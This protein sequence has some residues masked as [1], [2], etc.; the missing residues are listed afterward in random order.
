MRNPP[1]TSDRHGLTP[2]MALPPGEQVQIDTTRQ[3]VLA[4]FDDG[5][6]GRPELTIAVDVATSAILAAVLR[7]SSTQAID[8]APLLA[9]IAVPHP[10]RP[11]WPDTPRFAHSSLL[12]HQRLLT[13][14][15]R[16]QGAAARPAAVPETIVTDR[17]SVFTAAYETLGISVQASPPYTPTTKGIEKQAFDAINSLFCQ[18][19]PGYTGPD[20]TQRGPTPTLRPA[21][22]S[23]SSKTSSGEWLVHYR[24][25]PPRRPAPP[26]P[27][28]GRTHAEPD[29]DGPL[30]IGSYRRCAGQP[31]PNA[32]SACTTAPTTT[33][34]S[35]PT[36]AS[37][38]PSPH[39]AVSGRSTTTP[40]TPARSGYA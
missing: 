1:I 37:P 9:E 23:P 18:H 12:P 17:G 25:P 15:G 4:V 29:V 28:Q 20:T 34:S 40:T 36:T 11:T 8:A 31:S 32:A 3:D 35:P 21:T 22:P 30:S 19:L 33:P 6:M 16:L 24:H 2:T 13:L 27:A 7:P 5:A 14:D 38:R 26:G 10:A 39:A